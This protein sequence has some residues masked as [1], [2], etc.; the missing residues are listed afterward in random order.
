M[1]YIFIHFIVLF[2]C[3]Q[4]IEL[5]P[6]WTKMFINI[7]KKELR[8]Q[9]DHYTYKFYSTLNQYLNK[10]LLRFPKDFARFSFGFV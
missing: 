2:V 10:K 5:E 1:I 9:K 6:E 8:Q 7:N 3:S 4:S